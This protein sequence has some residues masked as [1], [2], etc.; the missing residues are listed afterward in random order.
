[1]PNSVSEEP[2]Q[3]FG[4]RLTGQFCSPRLHET[5]KSLLQRRQQSY[6]SAKST[7]LAH[8]DPIVNVLRYPLPLIFPQ[9][10]NALLKR[11]GNK[12][13]ILRYKQMDDVHNTNLAIIRPTSSRP[14]RSLMV[15]SAAL[16][17]F[18]VLVGARER[19]IERTYL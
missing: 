10:R 1:M 11:V 17:R 5:Q 4:E 2:R 13:A 8:E 15:A 7:P 16:M 14:G 19:A 9:L 18:R 12:P 3:K 6:N